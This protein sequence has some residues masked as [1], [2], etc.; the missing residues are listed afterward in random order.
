[1]NRVVYQ[2]F[3]TAAGLSAALGIVGYMAA[4]W[5]LTLVNAAPEVRAEALPFLRMMFVGIVG[6][7]MFF[8]LSGAFRA[9][10]IRVPRCDSD[11]R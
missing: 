9:A 3:L 2:S 1:V 11:W 5:L 10:G 8:M 7:I 4:P 6:L